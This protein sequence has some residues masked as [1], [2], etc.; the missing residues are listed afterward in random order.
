MASLV[1][2]YA[3]SDEETPVATAPVARTTQAD[4]ADLDDDAAEQQAR[5]DVYGLKGSER[6]VPSGTTAGWMG[7][8][9]GVVSAAPD[10]LAE[11]SNLQYAFPT[12]PNFSAGSECANCLDYSPNG[13]SD[14]RQYLIRRHDASDARSGE[15]VRHE[16]E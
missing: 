10:V 4:D 12:R 16:D 14:E 1:A 11:V 15:P 2:D 7:A 6:V 5:A 8:A 9:G 13:Q 3:S